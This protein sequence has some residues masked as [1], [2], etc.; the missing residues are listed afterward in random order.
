M[1]DFADSRAAAGEEANVGSE[2]PDRNQFAG[3]CHSERSE[4]SALLGTDPSL[5]AE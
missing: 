2:T 1:A 3:C 5:H 4:E